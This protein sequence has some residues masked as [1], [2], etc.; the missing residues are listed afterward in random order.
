MPKDEFSPDDPYELISTGFDAS[1]EEFDHMATCIIEELMFMGYNA[2]MVIAVF[3]SPFYQLP[4]SILKTKGEQY[5]VSK[6]KEVVEKWGLSP[7]KEEK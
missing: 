2:A 5:L 7:R 1:P 6:I 4:H 3:R